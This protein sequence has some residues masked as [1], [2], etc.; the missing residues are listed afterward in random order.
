MLYGLLLVIQNVVLRTMQPIMQGLVIDYF[1]DNGTTKA[2]VTLYATGLI[3][4]T[5]GIT[6]LLHHTN[7]GSQEIGMR[8]RIACCSLVYR[9]ALRLSLSALNQTATGQVVNLLSND[10]NRFDMLPLHL[11]Q[12]WVMPIQVA[13]IGYVMWQS[14][15]IA[16]LVG[17]GS[18]TILTIPI[19]GYLSKL[20]AQLRAIIARKTDKRVH[21][22]SEL[23]AGIQV[24]KMYGWEEPFE[25][26]V[27]WTRRTEIKIIRYSSYLRAFYLSIM[28]YTERLTLFLTLIAFILMGNT[29]TADVTFVLATYFNILQMTMAIFFPQAI[30]TGG[31]ALVSIKRLE[32]FLMLDEI[33]QINDNK[34]LLLK[35]K[36]NNK[37]QKDMQNKCTIA[38]KEITNPVTVELYRVSANWIPSQLPPTLHDISIKVEGGQ[39]CALI[40]PVGSG[41]SSLLNVLLKELPIG[42][43][44]VWLCQNSSSKEGQNNRGY[45]SDNPNLRIS[46]CSQ[47][48]WLFGATIRNNILFGQAYDKKRYQ[49][50]TKVC[51]LLQDFKQLPRGDMS[52]VGERGASLSGGQRARVNLARAVYRRADIYLFDDPLSAVD[53]RVGQHLFNECIINYLKG[54]TRIL[55]THQLQYLK[56][57]DTVIV[58]DREELNVPSLV[59]CNNLDDTA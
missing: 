48:P 15:G 46:Y 54:K 32:E 14:V 49:E 4:I 44:D 31:E 1:S 16:T 53:A 18:L 5:V 51:A 55:V 17:I 45:H 38:E 22:M 56:Q 34:E 50:V 24:V 9:K 58:L 10:V 41:K 25:K 43:G 3:L 30:I 37:Q 26:M 11:H 21:L 8:I 28:V 59:C 2:E 20:S 36:D 52:I 57:A 35:Q 19:Q 42:A 39:L 7:L 12:I 29:L 40:G 47:E 6:F 23:I 13:L 33:V 27:S